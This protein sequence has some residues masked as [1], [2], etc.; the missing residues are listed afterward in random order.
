MTATIYHLPCTDA[1]L[2]ALQATLIEAQQMHHLR[3]A[4]IRQRQINQRQIIA[5]MAALFLA[6][7]A[8]TA[9]GQAVTAHIAAS[10]A[11]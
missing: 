7:L 5:M 11:Q 8:V 10:L 3:P 2:A 9:I 1:E 4:R 6:C